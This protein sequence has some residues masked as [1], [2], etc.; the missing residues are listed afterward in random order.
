MTQ[1]KK[2]FVKLRWHLAGVLLIKIVLLSLL[3][4][5]CIKPYKVVVDARVMGERVGASSTQQ[6]RENAHD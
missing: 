2:P 3:W 6:L 4:H 1:R 5:A